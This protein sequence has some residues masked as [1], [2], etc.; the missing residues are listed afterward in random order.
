MQAEG[1]GTQPQHVLLHPGQFKDLVDALNPPETDQERLERLAKTA[2]GGVKFVP[3]AE[4]AGIA[5][6]VEEHPPPSPPTPTTRVPTFSE[7]RASKEASARRHS[8]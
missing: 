8:L 7:M 2:K 5:H 1:E 4:E 6:Q 3:N